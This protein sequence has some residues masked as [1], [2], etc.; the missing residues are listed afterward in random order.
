M[1]K[2]YINKTAAS[3]HLVG[4]GRSTLHTFTNCA[5][6]IVLAWKR[7]EQREREREREREIDREG[8]KNSYICT[9]EHIYIQTRQCICTDLAC[10]NVQICPHRPG[11]GGSAG[12][13]GETSKIVSRGAKAPKGAK[14][15][16]SRF[17]NRKK[18]V[19][20]CMKTSTYIVLKYPWMHV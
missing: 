12:A 3:E 4:Q 18:N 11:G 2:Y 15:R 20:I 8:K 16:S 9:N 6:K 1:K 14:P 13:N 10:T 5:H 17:V 19:E 7:V